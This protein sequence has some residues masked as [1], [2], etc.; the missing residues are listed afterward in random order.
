ML[1]ILLFAGQQ[2][3]TVVF[4]L[5]EPD[6]PVGRGLQAALLQPAACQELVVNGGLEGSGGWQFGPTPAPGVVVTAPVHSG[7]FAI[8]LGIAGGANVAAYSTAYQSITLPA[9]AEQIVLTFWER[10]G[11]TGDSADYREVLLL[12]PNLTVLRRLA[13]QNGPGNDEWTQRTFDLTDLRGQQ[14]VLYFNVYNNGSGATLVNYLDDISIQSCDGAATSTPTATPIE[15]PTPGDTPTLPLTLTPVEPAE[16]PTATATAT[17]LP[18]NLMVRAGVVTLAA[19]QAAV[20][21]PLE[22]AGATGQQPVGILSIAVQYDASVL[23]AVACPVSND[24]DLLLCSV[25]AP[26]LIRLVGVAATGIRSDLKVADLAFEVSQPENLPAQLT[27]QLD[28]VADVEGDALSA[29]AENGQIRAACLPGAEDCSA[30]IY[31]YL[32]LVQGWES[33][34]E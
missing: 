24:F 31:F 8:R 13:R 5:H 28:A 29:A 1:L 2:L 26:G 7:S 18:G 17:P 33:G 15:T 30:D 9:A 4:Q 10:P 16:T 22:L 23:N 19:G 12:R 25:A 27:V 20:N 32:P 21:A 11:A 6:R 3:A 34:D 14:V